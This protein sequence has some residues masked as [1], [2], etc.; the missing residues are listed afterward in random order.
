MDRHGHRALLEHGLTLVEL[1]VTLVVA[2]VLLT[3]AVPSLSAM[4]HTS[5]LRGVGDNLQAQLRFAM[6]EST[7]RNRSISVTFKANADGSSWCY[8]MS[9]DSS[10]DC[11]VSGSCVYDSVERVARS[12]DYRGVIVTVS[13]SQGRFSFQSK[14]NTVTAGSISFTSANGKQLRTVVSGYGRIRTCSPSGD[15][16]LAGYPVC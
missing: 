13:V 11:G 9:E 10:C 2:S 1:L 12:D 16:N 14:R 7:K 15:A 6:A 4:L 3:I 5:R 8:G